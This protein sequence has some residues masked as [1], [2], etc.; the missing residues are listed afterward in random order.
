MNP[1]MIVHALL[2]VFLIL[3]RN[4]INEGMFSKGPSPTISSGA[5]RPNPTFALPL[6][7]TD[8]VV[9]GSLFDSGGNGAREYE[10][11]INVAK[12]NTL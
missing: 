10:S 1:V 12:S 4:N 9:S 6:H 2:G 3:F 5:I 7:G 8:V 11:L